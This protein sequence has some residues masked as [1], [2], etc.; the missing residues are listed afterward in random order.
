MNEE[1]LKKKIKELEGEYLVFPK[2]TKELVEN[3]IIHNNINL[4]KRELEGFQKGK[5]EQKKEELMFLDD[6]F[7]V[8][9]WEKYIQSDSI[10]KL[11]ERIKQLQKEIGGNEK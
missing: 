6:C 11:I 8:Y 5:L 4:L 7:R 10:S 1:E 9:R 2:G 3:R